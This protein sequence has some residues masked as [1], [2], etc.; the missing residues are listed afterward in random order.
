MLL[1][2][3]QINYVS[4]NQLH[5]TSHGCQILNFGTVTAKYWYSVSKA[6]HDQVFSVPC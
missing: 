4:K 5:N 2:V 6:K 1:K 3:T